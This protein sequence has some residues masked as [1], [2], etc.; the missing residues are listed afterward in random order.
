MKNDMTAEECLV[1]GF[2]LN[3]LGKNKDALKALD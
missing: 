1:E 3:A 2:K